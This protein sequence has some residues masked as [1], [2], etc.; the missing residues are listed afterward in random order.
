MT[1]CRRGPRADNAE[2][3]PR[4]MLSRL[5][6]TALALAV[7]ASPSPLRCRRRKTRF[8]LLARLYR[9]GLVTHRI[10]LKGFPDVVITSLPPFPSFLAQCHIIFVKL[11]RTGRV[12]VGV[13]SHLSR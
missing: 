1:V 11:E 5:N 12:E 13:A 10:P 4:V 6:S 8:R 7:Y 2:G 3:S 9:V